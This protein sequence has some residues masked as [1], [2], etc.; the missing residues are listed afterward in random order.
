[1]WDLEFDRVFE[2]FGGNL[3]VYGCCYEQDEGNRYVGVTS[4]PPLLDESADNH[5]AIFPE[6]LVK[7]G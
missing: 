1:M 7:V 3:W 5:G 6:L 4:E 2:I